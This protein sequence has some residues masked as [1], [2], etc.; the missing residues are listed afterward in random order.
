MKEKDFQTKFGK[1]LKANRHETSVYELKVTKTNSLP[2]SAIAD[3]QVAGL[4]HAKHRE[5]YMKLPDVG[6]Q[7]PFDCF[8]LCK[9]E[10]YVV[11]LYPSKCFYAIDIDDFQW[12][13]QTSGRRSLTE[14]EARE[15][16]TFSSFTGR[17]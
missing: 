7:M 12:K 1:W 4:Y 16:S 5:L 10:A 13:N 14:D 6:Y 3:H 15:L 2:F 17:L 9:V 11:I 8:H